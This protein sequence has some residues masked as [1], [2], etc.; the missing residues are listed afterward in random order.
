MLSKRLASTAAICLLLAAGTAACGDNKDKASATPKLDTEK[1][2][3]Q[4][5][6]K[7][8]KDALA[9]AS[10]VKIV[11]N[12]VDGDGKMEISLA[13]DTKGQCTGSLS[14]PGTGKFEIISDGKETYL[15]PDKDFWTAVAGPAGEKAAE[16]FKGRY[17]SGFQG[18]P[19]M[20]ELTTVC[21][22]KELSK[23]I[24]E[25]DSKKSTVAKGS[26]GTVNG[27]KTFS[28]KS[29]GPDG[30]QATIHVATE[31]KFYP[32][33]VEQNKGTETGQTDFTDFDKPL[34]VQAP[35]A[36]NVIDFSKFKDELKSA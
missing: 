10:S 27:V 22:L 32:V 30:Q 29:T 7:Q 18:D 36:D 28:L 8:A 9:G 20:K 26:A 25:D 17:L 24:V 11:G 12:V 34:T 35:P 2:S 3:A 19:D 1:L 6:E 5:I 33:R 16:L 4:E 21:N 23:K 13:L 31:G 14:M 15:K